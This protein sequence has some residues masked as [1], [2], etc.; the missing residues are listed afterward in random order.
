MVKS[1]Y[2]IE[3]VLDLQVVSSF[4]EDGEPEIEISD[5]NLTRL[6][7]YAFDLQVEFR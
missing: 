3:E 2:T 5:Y 6:T 4:Y 1:N 7:E